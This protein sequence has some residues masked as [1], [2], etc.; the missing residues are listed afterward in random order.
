MTKRFLFVLPSL[1]PVSQRICTSSVGVQRSG[2]GRSF[3]VI[4]QFETSLAGGFKWDNT[5]SG[6]VE[7]NPTTSHVYDAPN[8]FPTY[9]T[10]SALGTVQRELTLVSGKGT[11]ALPLM[12][13]QAGTLNNVNTMNYVGQSLKACGRLVANARI[14]SFYA[15]DS[16]KTIGTVGATVTDGA[17][18]D[19]EVTFNISAGRIRT[20]YPGMFVD[21]WDATGVTQRNSGVYTVVHSVDYLN[22][23][24]TLVNVGAATVYFDSQVVA[25]DIVTW[26]DSKSQGSSG[27]NDWLVN[28]GTLYGMALADYP[29][30]KS[31]IDTSVGEL[32]EWELNRYVGSFDEAYGTLV[33]LDTII[34]TGGVTRNFVEQT[35]SYAR[36]ERQGSAASVEAGWSNFGYQYNGKHFDWLV[37]NNCA[38]G[39]L[40]GVKLKGENIKRYIPPRVPSAG[41]QADMPAD[42]QFFAESAGSTSI[43][44]PTRVNDAVAEMVEA[45]FYMYEEIAPLYPQGIKLTGVTEANAPL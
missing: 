18:D 39:H 17:T 40:Y 27:L 36:Y 32:T 15:T 20:F 21:L 35:G 31:L 5:L 22:L 29:Q 11:F 38:S 24:M 16:L 34:T 14:A 10:A 28:S 45:P 44:L 9:T 4:H 26:R 41:S 30:L 1:D 6:D 2:I 13:A 25:T 42:I 7:T 43:F 3:K 23:T 8:T 33:D 37:S 19:N 12:I